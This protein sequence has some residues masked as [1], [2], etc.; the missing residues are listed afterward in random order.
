MRVYFDTAVM[1]AASVGDHPHHTRGLNALQSVRSGKIEGY[2]SG[3]GLA[4]IYAV[5]TRTPFIPPVYPAQAWQ[6]LRENVLDCFS[7]VN[8]SAEMYR[9]T[10]QECAVHGWSGGRVY[11]ALHLACARASACKRIYTF[12]V[13]HFQLLAPDLEDS[14][15]AP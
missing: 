8:I 6:L 7:L 2:I 5:L 13:R 15:A 3:H 10:V 4:E 11:D 14:I 9:R 1:V 12:N